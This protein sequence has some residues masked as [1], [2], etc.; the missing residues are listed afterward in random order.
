MPEFVLF[1][2]VT[3]ANIQIKKPTKVKSLKS[4]NHE[5]IELELEEVPQK[6]ER[7]Q[8]RKINSH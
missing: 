5:I 7:R 8:N 6:D 2:R 4:V 1:F 3:S